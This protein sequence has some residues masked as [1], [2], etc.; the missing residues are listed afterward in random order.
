VARL[1]RVQHE[2][3]LTLVEH[4]D[5][6]RSRLI[7]SQIVLTIG[8][9]VGFWKQH[10]ILQYLLKPG[11][12][13]LQRSDILLGRSPTSGFFIAVS[14]SLYF[15]VLVTLPVLTYQLYSFV[16][17]AFAPD[18]HK[19]MRLLA[20]FIP[21][22]FLVGAA[23]GWFVVVPAALDFLLA[24]NADQVHYQMEPGAYIQFIALTMA[25]MGVIFEMPAIMLTLASLR[26]VT[27]SR[28]RRTWRYA[29]VLLALVAGI[30]PGADPVSFVAEFVPLLLL[31]GISYL[32][33]AL[34]DR[35]RAR[36][37]VG[38]EGAE[39]A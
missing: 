20:L 14:I 6:L 22:L 24:F 33:V 1:R 31:Y 23:F 26:I 19:K 12:S 5:E 18:Y 10:A 25:A 11:Q 39:P 13:A 32:L 2:D 15:A 36:S 35:R 28:M 27:A 8:V 4:L 17:P 34:V 37:E 16:V 29:V 9:S 38:D 30:L 7:A 3:Q 21:L